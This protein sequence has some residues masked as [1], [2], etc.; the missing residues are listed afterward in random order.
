MQRTS[1]LGRGAAALANHAPLRRSLLA[2][3]FMLTLGVLYPAFLGLIFLKP[4]FFEHA[5]Q[6][7][8]GFVITGIALTLLGLCFVLATLH[9]RAAERQTR[10]T[11]DTPPSLPPTSA[12]EAQ[13][14]PPVNQDA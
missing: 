6:S 10:H 9:F 5:F 7:Y 1:E 11:F 12:Q 4:E 13:Q 2:P 14:L 8:S 3:I